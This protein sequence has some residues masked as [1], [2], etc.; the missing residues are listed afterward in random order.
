M[1][2]L[3]WQGELT[4]SLLSKSLINLAIVKRQNEIR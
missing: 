2:Y 1:R 4:M 3:I